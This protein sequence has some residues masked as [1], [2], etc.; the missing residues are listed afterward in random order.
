MPCLSCTIQTCK[1][2]VFFSIHRTDLGTNFGLAVQ[3][4]PFLWDPP[5]GLDRDHQFDFI[6]ACLQPP[7]PPFQATSTQRSSTS[8]KKLKGCLCIWGPNFN[9]FPI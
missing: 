9:L 8:H 4:P 7:P 1:G 2:E 3:R 5:Q 6:C